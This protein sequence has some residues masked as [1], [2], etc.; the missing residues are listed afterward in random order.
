MGL[1]VVAAAASFAVALRGVDPGDFAAALGA[2]HWDRTPWLVAAV[3]LNHAVRVVRWHLLLHAAP[4]RRTVPIA[5]TAFLAM[6]LLPLRLGEAVRPALH[7]ADGISLDRSVAALVSER[8]LDLVLL[9][10]LIGWVSTAVALPDTITVGGVDVVATAQRG[11]ALLVIVGGIAVVAF[12]VLGERLAPRMPVGAG[13]VRGLG[14]G[15]RSLAS[16]PVRAAWV[17]ALTV[18]TWASTILYVAAGLACFPGVPSGVPVAATAWAA[19]VSGITVLPTPVFFG[20]YEASGTVALRLFGTAPSTA[21]AAVLFLHLA[22]VVIVAVP[23]L[24]AMA[25]EGTGTKTLQ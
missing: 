22:Y 16:D 11:A 6:T 18:G 25:H 14:Q 5:L 10:L 7:T 17:V 19:I 21:A 8:L 3:L 12:A 4:W 13:F 1:L 23:G 9:L 15:F 2:I 20:A 24:L